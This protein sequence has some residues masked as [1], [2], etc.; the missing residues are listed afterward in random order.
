LVSTL[1][2]ISIGLRCGSGRPRVTGLQI[3]CNNS[4]ASCIDSETTLTLCLFNKYISYEWN[5]FYN[6]RF[7]E[8]LQMSLENPS[9]FYLLENP[10]LGTIGPTYIVDFNLLPLLSP[11]GQG[12]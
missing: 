5:I 4:N 8:S 9:P 10:G 7:M 11:A 6:R 3:S 1:L 2:A 12:I